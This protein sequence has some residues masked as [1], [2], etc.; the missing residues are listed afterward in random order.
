MTEERKTVNACSVRTLLAV[1]GIILFFCLMAIIMSAVIG[2]KG[3]DVGDEAGILTQCQLM[4]ERRLVAPSTAKFS[5]LRDTT[6]WKTNQPGD[7]WGVLGYV[8]SQ[9]RFG[10]TVRTHYLCI[11]RY[12][13]DNRWTLTE[14]DLTDR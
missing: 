2:G 6:I 1:G 11:M 5:P 3:E 12:D 4:M 13:G 7:N 9:N 14:F 8:D 10:A